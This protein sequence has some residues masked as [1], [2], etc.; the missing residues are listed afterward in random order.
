MSEENPSSKTLVESLENIM[1]ECQEKHAA[2]MKKMMASF[3][4]LERELQRIMDDINKLDVDEPVSLATDAAKL[5]N[6]TLSKV[7]EEDQ[8]KSKENNHDNIVQKVKK[9]GDKAVDNVA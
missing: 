1:G 9:E 7:T 8:I 3:D 5:S 4:S 2:Q 6:P